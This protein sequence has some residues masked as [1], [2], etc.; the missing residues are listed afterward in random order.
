M[1]EKI[2]VKLFA[3]QKKL[4]YISTYNHENANA[5]FKISIEFES[6]FGILIK[7]HNEKFYFIY[8]EYNQSTQK[9]FQLCCE[10]NDENNRYKAFSTGFN[11]MNF[12]VKE[13]L[14]IM[15]E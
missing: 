2:I 13:C 5:L 8:R 4:F 10:F 15:A 14:N 1:K 9:I 12:Y 3:M 11:K 6:L 7:T